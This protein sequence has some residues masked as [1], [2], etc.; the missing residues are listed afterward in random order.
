[1]VKQCAIFYEQQF[2][3]IKFHL[4]IM[5]LDQKA[6]HQVHIDDY[7]LYGMAD[8]ESLINKLFI[9]ADKKAIGALLGE[10]DTLPDSLLSDFDCIVLHE[11]GHFFFTKYENIYFSRRWTNE[12]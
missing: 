4:Q 7:Q 2:P 5:V 3:D 11:L 10:T 12:F 6:W 9:G 1:M 8:P